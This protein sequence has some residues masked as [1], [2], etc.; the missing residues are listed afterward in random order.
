MCA[1]QR[2]CCDPVSESTQMPCLNLL[3]R[4]PAQQPNLNNL[5]DVFIEARVAKG[6]MYL[7]IY[8]YIN[9]NILARAL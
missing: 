4:A 5:L 1:T 8:I 7:Y 6:S 3:F 9:D 2:K